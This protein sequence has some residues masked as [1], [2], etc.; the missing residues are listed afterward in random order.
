MPR[1]RG[2][3]GGRRESILHTSSALTEALMKRMTLT[4]LLA[5]TLLSACSSLP[6]RE[7]GA[8]L[9]RYT[10]YLGAPVPQFN[11][12]TRYDGWSTVDNN[13]VVIRTNVDEAYLLTVAP[14]CDQLPFAIR[15]GIQ[16]RIR[17]TVASG[18]DSIRVGRQR[19]LITEIRPVNYKQMKTDLAAERKQQTG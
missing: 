7:A 10:P 18:F 15:L 6:Q 13:H 8:E 19:C 4:S 16:S 11:M 9:A 5:L 17:N 3:R 14:M 12:Y 1:V 2:T